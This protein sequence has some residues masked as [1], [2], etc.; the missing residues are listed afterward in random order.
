MEKVGG[1]CDIYIYIGPPVDA[2]TKYTLRG[3]AS[4]ILTQT[5]QLHC[6]FKESMLTAVVQSLLKRTK[7]A[8][9]N[10]EICKEELRI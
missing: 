9:L 4:F 1:F 10:N 3:N 7:H 2:Q 5:S 6:D 8:K